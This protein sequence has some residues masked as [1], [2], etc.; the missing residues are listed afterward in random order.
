MKI[1]ALS[2]LAVMAY[3]TDD[4]TFSSKRLYGKDVAQVYHFGDAVIV[5][6]PAHSE[7]PVKSVTFSSRRTIGG[8]WQGDALVSA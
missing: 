8:N 4:I 1:F 7:L 2:A 6:I 5:D 3:A